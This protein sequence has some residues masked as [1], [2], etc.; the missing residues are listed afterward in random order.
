VVGFLLEQALLQK[1]SNI[2]GGRDERDGAHKERRKNGSRYI[3][4]GP[5]LAN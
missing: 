1:R 2:V 4:H 3:F 5:S